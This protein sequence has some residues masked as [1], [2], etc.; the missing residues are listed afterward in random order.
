MKRRGVLAGIA[1]GGAML[2]LP[3]T[4]DAIPVADIKQWHL[5]TDVLVAGSG[6]AGLAAAIDAR[7][8]GADVLLVEKL[9]R[10]GGSSS[11]SGGVVYCGGGT[12]LQ[13]SLG[14]EHTVEAMYGYIAESGRKHPHLDKIQLYCEQSVEHFDWLVGN[15]VPYNKQFTPAKGLSFDESS[16]YFSGNE[17]AWPWRDKWAPIPRGHVPWEKGHQ[18]GR[19]LMRTLIASAQKQGVA[20]MKRVAG[21]RLVLAGDGRVV[22]AVVTIAGERKAIKARRGVVLACG[23]FIH[24][25]DMVKQHAPELYDV[26][27]PWAN[28]GDTGD[29]I[30]MGVGVGASAIRMDQGFSIGPIYAK[31][32]PCASFTGYHGCRTISHRFASA[33]SQGISRRQDGG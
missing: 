33:G 11:L 6:A 27:A 19:K 25:R 22:G 30:L 28:A 9:N 23:G 21:E 10:Y 5:S 17:E 4:S 8:A 7:R 32:R 3:L 18:G 31:T 29:G 24:N 20:M 2:S 16:L 12:A 1:G 26:S 13:K 14:F 15:G